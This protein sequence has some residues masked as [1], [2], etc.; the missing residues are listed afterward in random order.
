[1]RPFLYPSFWQSWSFKRIDAD[2]E[3]MKVQMA[4]KKDGVDGEID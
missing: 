2:V 4:K 1:M 3:K